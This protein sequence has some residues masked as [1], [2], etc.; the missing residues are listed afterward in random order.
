[1]AS[2]LETLSGSTP[3]ALSGTLFC[4]WLPV[5]RG[6]ETRRMKIGTAYLGRLARECLFFSG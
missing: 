3:S 6:S 2:P 1:M 5:L 4:L